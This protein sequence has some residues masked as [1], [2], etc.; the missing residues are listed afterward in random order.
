MSQ[1]NV[2]MVRRAYAAWNAGDMDGLREMYSPDAMQVRG[3]EGW[4]E[5]FSPVIG[6]EAVIRG[7]EQLRETWDA[8]SMQP[9]SVVDAGDSVVVRTIWRGVGHGP[10]LNMEMTIVFTLRKGKIFLLESFWDHAD[11]LEAL[12]LSE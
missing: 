12:G 5:P 3:L 8:D 2:E 4:P 11:A 1:Q 6:R 10:D 9:V 7:F